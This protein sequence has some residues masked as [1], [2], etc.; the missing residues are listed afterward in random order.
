MGRTLQWLYVIK[1][2]E[3]FEEFCSLLSNHP[4]W[5]KI[6]HESASMKLMGAS[7]LLFV[8]HDDGGGTGGSV[9]QLLRPQS[10]CWCWNSDWAGRGTVASLAHPHGRRHGVVPQC[11]SCAPRLNYSSSGTLH[12]ALH[13]L[14]ADFARFQLFSHCCHSQLIYCTD[15]DFL[16]LSLN[17]SSF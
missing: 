13:F 5:C 16:L 3:I 15:K 8:F 2:L 14:N 1:Y 4:L 11:R 10:P 9:M 12:P 7:I 6:I 17:S